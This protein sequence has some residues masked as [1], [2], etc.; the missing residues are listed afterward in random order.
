TGGGR[1]RRNRTKRGAAAPS[2][3]AAAA[4]TTASTT[5]N[6][7]SSGP[8]RLTRRTT[9]GG[10]STGG[11]STGGGGTGGGGTGISPPASTTTPSPSS[12]ASSDDFP[13]TTEEV[14]SNIR[15]ALPA[16]KQAE[17]DRTVK[18]DSWTPRRRKVE[19]EDV[20]SQADIS[21]LKKTLTR[22]EVPLHAAGVGPVVFREGVVWDTLQCKI[23]AF[24]VNAQH[25]MGGPDEYKGKNAA[26]VWGNNVY[27]LGENGKLLDG[28]CCTAHYLGQVME[29]CG[30]DRVFVCDASG[31]AHPRSGSALKKDH[32]GTRELVTEHVRYLLGSGRRILKC[33]PEERP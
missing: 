23:L 16:D 7:T 14:R 29:R 30:L 4:A 25:F 6:T 13:V 11:G 33:T 12:T 9:S 8:T 31:V 19:P 24:P 26:V 22:R 3:A 2:P 18:G 28:Q 21:E 10:G 15:A 27:W 32:A 20:K 1:Q 5:G 17:W